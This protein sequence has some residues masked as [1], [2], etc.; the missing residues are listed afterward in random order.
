MTGPD[1]PVAD[2]GPCGVFAWPAPIDLV[3]ALSD[4][5]E[6]GSLPA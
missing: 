6:L 1:T 2:G 5:F 4:L 3:S